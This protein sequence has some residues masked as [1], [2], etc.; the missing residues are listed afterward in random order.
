[1]GVVLLSRILYF[2]VQIGTRTNIF[3]G[4]QVVYVYGFG[5]FCRILYFRVHTGTKTNL[6]NGCLVV[7]V[8]GLGAF[9]RILYFHV[10]TGT[11]SNLFNRGFSCLCLRGLVPL[12]AYCTT[13]YK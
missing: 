9:S 3:N 8:Y 2:R 13:G 4:F 12:A 6:F 5:A 7:Y 1:M 10:Q 11:K